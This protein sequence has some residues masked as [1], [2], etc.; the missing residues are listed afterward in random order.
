MND[1]LTNLPN[2][3]SFLKRLDAA[4]L[5]A[6]GELDFAV[7]CLDV[8]GFK[9]VNDSFGHSVGD[10]LLQAVANRLPDQWMIGHFDLAG[11]ILGAG[12]LVGEHGC[13]Q[14]LRVH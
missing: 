11:Q 4:R 3:S 13:Q 9:G 6:G 10:Q 2:R 7:L 12:H 1:S 8:D 14:I 5:R